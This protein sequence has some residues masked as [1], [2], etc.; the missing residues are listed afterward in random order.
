MFIFS[1]QCIE[2]LNLH[3]GRKKF[4]G[5][6]SSMKNGHLS[7]KNLM[8]VCKMVEEFCILRKFLSWPTDLCVVDVVS[9][10]TCICV[11]LFNWNWHFQGAVTDIFDDGVLIQFE[12]GW[13]SFVIGI[14]T[15]N[16]PTKPTKNHFGDQFLFTNSVYPSDL[17]GKKNQN[18]PSIKFVYLHRKVCKMKCSPRI[19]KWKC[20]QD[21]TI[22]KLVDGGVLSS[23]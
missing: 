20:S 18:F 7:K 13:V 10:A 1:G 5:K 3:F 8:S 12:D 22:T 16:A 21:P 23:R 2:Q 17:D 4:I 6:F 14:I 15:R 19:W 9:C 11:F